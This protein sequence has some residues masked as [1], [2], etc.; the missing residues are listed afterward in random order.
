MAH[1]NGGIS[2][3]SRLFERVLESLCDAPLASTGDVAEELS[4]HEERQQALLELLHTRA[5]DH[6]DEDRLLSLSIAAKFFRVS[7]MLYQRRREFGQILDCY[8]LDK[9][10]QSLVFAYIKQ[11]L[12][13]PDISVEEKRKIRD[14][15]LQH[16]EDLICIDARK[17]TKLL[18]VNMDVVLVE[19][20]NRVVSYYKEDLTFDFLQCLFEIADS[21]TG[22]LGSDD[23]QFEPSVYERYIELLCQQSMLEAVVAFLRSHDGYRLTKTLEICQRFRFSEAVIVVLEKFGDVS[24]AFEAALQSLRTK[25]SL[26]VRSDDVNLR[27]LMKPVQVAVET[28]ISLLNRNSPRLEQGQH[29][30]LWFTLVDLLIDNYNRLFSYK[31]DGSGVNGSGKN[32]CQSPA[33][34]QYSDC[35]VSNARDEYQ[36]ILQYTVNCMV[37]HVPF[38]AVLE[39]IVTLGDED[40]IASCFGNV[41]DLLSSVMDACRYQQAV[42]R[43]CARIVQQDVNGALRGLTVAARSPISP[44]FDTCSAC[45]QALN[46]ARK[47]G[48]V[49]VISFQCGHAFHRPCLRDSARVGK[50]V[51]ES[52][53]PADG[54]WYCVICCRS[55]TRFTVPYARS[56]VVSIGGQLECG[57]DSATNQLLIPVGSVEQLRHSQ[58]TASR[59]EILSELRQLEEAKTV[60]SSSVWKGNGGRA[61]ALQGEKFSLK[62]AAPPAQQSTSDVG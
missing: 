54:Q 41:R 20:V 8:C 21:C 50:D 57:D 11:T 29:R 44:H 31:V 25:L 19:A 46:D 5:L 33:S 13:S 18:T 22:E 58:R 55:R 7:E 36:S 10:R 56:R 9:A 2:V 43:T 15:V 47:F 17:T 14:A 59:L 35:G 6:F 32:C 42:Y 37:S 26:M 28:V 27:E 61:S 24:G 49:P 4:H 52:G 48:E 53:T 30:Q 60:R 23:W 3:D 40:G 51:E 62:L 34:S 39:H 1:P 16:L 12:A 38:T 45:Q